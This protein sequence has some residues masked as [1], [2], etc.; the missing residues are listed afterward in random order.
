MGAQSRECSGVSVVLSSVQSP[1][2]APPQASRVPLPTFLG[3]HRSR[4]DSFLAVVR[5]LSG[6]GAFLSVGLLCHC[7]LKPSPDT[8]L[9]S[10]ILHDKWLSLWNCAE[11]SAFERR[12]A[13]IQ[14]PL[15]GPLDALRARWCAF[16]LS[17]S[18]L[19]PRSETTHLRGRG[20]AA[21]AYSTSR[22]AYR[23]I[24]RPSLPKL[25][26]AARYEFLS[27]LLCLF[28][29]G[30][31]HVNSARNMPLL[32]REVSSIALHYANLQPPE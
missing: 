28:V 27:A 29:V 12:G 14:G 31:F 22:G 25:S 2:V 26:I 9:F 3:D 16:D 32:I 17:G 21:R 5:G 23:A 20:E 18:W 24:S 19:R 13:F 30:A 8:Q 6:F 4:T 15:S 1:N 10:P 11:R 7:Q